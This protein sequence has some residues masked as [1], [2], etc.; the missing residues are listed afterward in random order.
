MN[1]HRLL[2]SALSQESRAAATKT[3]DEDLQAR[4]LLQAARYTLLAQQAAKR[5]ETPAK[6]TGSSWI[7]DFINRVRRVGCGGWAG[8]VELITGIEDHR[9]VWRIVLR[10]E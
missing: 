6:K 1:F 8:K 10:P 9:P 3:S 4:L 7:G 5:H 2:W